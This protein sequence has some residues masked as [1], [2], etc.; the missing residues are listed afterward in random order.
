[1]LAAT[2]QDTHSAIV[3]RHPV[4]RRLPRPVRIAQDVLTTAVYGGVRLGIAVLGAGAAAVVERAPRTRESRPFTGSARGRRLAGLVDGAFGS[5]LEASRYPGLAGPMTIRVDGAG[6]ALD[7]AALARHHPAA[8]GTVVVLVHG[9]IE[10]E[11]WWRPAPGGDD[12]GARLAA[13]IGATCVRVR[14]NSGQP[15]ARS[16]AELDDL[17]TRLVD[18][19]PVPLHRIDLVGHSMGGLVARIA[20]RR[21]GSWQSRV[22]HLV[23]LGTPHRGSPVERAAHGAAALLA[24][25][26][27]TAP[28]GALLDLRSAGIKDL[29]HGIGPDPVPPDVRHR[30]IAATLSSTPTGLLG[31]SLG[32][33]LVLP[34]S[35]LTSTAPDSSRA[36]G[37]L[38]HRDLLHHDSV[39]AVLREWLL[40]GDPQ[41]TGKVVK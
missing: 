37:G 35:A 38:A 22:H 11:D 8:T 3:R 41:C 29:R 4:L 2:V 23:C 32:D 36:L 26:E 1:V 16:G 17:L 25:S 40:G 34:A 33:L 14:Y 18:A 21:A 5:H 27:L 13:D 10:T 19:W 12:F 6:I 30:D 28:V 15:V 39:Y 9:L 24:R 20:L 31:R 7:A